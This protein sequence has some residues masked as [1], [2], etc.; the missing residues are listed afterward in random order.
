MATMARERGWGGGGGKRAT[1]KLKG[2][3]STCCLGWGGVGV[4]G[5][6]EQRYPF[7]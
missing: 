2:F 5:G 7:T 1:K 3:I 4:G 6:G